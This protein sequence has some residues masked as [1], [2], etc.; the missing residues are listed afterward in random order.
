M[1]G[2]E[3][4]ILNIDELLNGQALRGRTKEELQEVLGHMSTPSF[5]RAVSNSSEP[6]YYDPLESMNR[7]DS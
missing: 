2:N 7:R 1:Q 4:N 5:V 3:T 6:L